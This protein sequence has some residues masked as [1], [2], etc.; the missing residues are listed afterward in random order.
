[1]AAWK[2][3]PALAAGNAILLKPSRRT[4]M[5]IVRAARL[6]G[7]LLP[8]GVLSVLPGDHAAIAPALAS[9]PRVAM[10]ALTGSL[11]AGAEIGRLTAPGAKRLHLELGGKTPVIVCADADLGRAT[12]VIAAAALDN[13]GQDCTAASRV[14]AVGPVYE[15]L[16]ARLAGELRSVRIGPPTDRS[17]TLGPVIGDDRRDWLVGHVDRAIEAG[18]RLV[19][20]GRR[21]DRP[22]FFLEPTLLA[23]V[24]RGMDITGEELFGPVLTIE[25]CPN[26]DAALER[27]NAGPTAL[28]A[29]IWT[30]SLA[31]ALRLSAEVDAGKVWVNEHHRDVTEMPHGGRK[32][33]GHGSDLS[34]YAMQAYSTPKSVH[35]RFGTDEAP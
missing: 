12:R 22:G 17:T 32:A 28:A 23:G 15:E 19:H 35:I 34:V 4:P 30:R 18:A 11:A 16:V 2:I 13:A 9:D 31:T 27:A 29:G 8:P 33:S 1:M 14:L 20:G 21:V 6:F 24:E 10:I 3:G 25:N 7:D 26:D 5:S